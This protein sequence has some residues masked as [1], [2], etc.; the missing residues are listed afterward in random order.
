[1]RKLFTFIVFIII[2][3]LILSSAEFD[4]DKYE[5][6]LDSTKNL[7]YE[8]LK[9]LYPSDPFYSNN[10][11]NLDSVNYYELSKS[12]LYYSKDEIDLLKNQSFVVSERFNYATFFHSIYDIW[13]KDLPI[14]LSYDLFLN[15][16]HTNFNDIFKDI[17]AENA[18]TLSSALDSTLD[19]LYRFKSLNTRKDKIYLNMVDDAELYL[20]IAK[21]LLEQKFEIQID[22]AKK[23]KI[24]EVLNFIEAEKP[25]SVKLFAKV[26]RLYDFSLFKPRGFYTETEYKHI[27]KS[28]TLKDYFKSIMWLGHINIYIS[29]PKNNAVFNLDDEDLDRHTRLVAFLSLLISKSGAK[30]LF[31]DIDQRLRLLV[32]DQDNITYNQSN[33]IIEKL[34]YSYDDL[35]E[36]ENI[37]RIRTEL[38]KLSSAK[39]TYNST[40]LIEGNPNEKIDAGAVF[41]VLG[42]RPLIDAFIT[43]KVVF[44]NIIYDG[45]KIRRMLP[46]SMDVLFALGN[47]ATLFGLK[48]ELNEYHYSSNLASVRYLIDGFEESFWKK[49]VYTNWLGVIRS[50]NPPLTQEERDTK[51]QFEQSA[52]WQQKTATAQLAS[53]AELRHDFILQG[54]QPTTSA[55]TC[56]FPDA[57]LEPNPEFFQY[58]LNI[59]NI[60]KD[61]EKLF[62]TNWEGINIILTYYSRLKD[63]SQDIEYKLPLS[64]EDKKFLKQVLFDCSYSSCDHN[65]TDFTGWL[66][67]LYYGRRFSNTAQ[68]NA[69]KGPRLAV[70]DIH[71]SPTDEDGNFVGWVKH[72]GTG[73]VNL[74]SVITDN[75]DEEKKIYTG[76]VYSFYEFTTENFHRLDDDEW[77]NEFNQELGG[78]FEKL[79]KSSI[80]KAYTTN[81]KGIVYSK[82]PIFET[83]ESVSAVNTVINNENRGVEV[84]PQ[85]ANNYVRFAF[86]NELSNYTG[87]ISLHSI[88]GDLIQLKNLHF[89]TSGNHIITLSLDR[90]ITSGTYIYRISLGGKEYNGKIIV[91]K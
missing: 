20:I 81:N 74:C 17:E 85:P 40:I 37:E 16:L 91:K 32:G 35:Y 78:T 82:I 14:Y 1:M 66:P 8:G 7:D 47:N 80:S 10:Y 53:W 70:A 88:D 52:L 3:N 39:Q 51:R 30:L 2:S 75:D 9:V 84:Y 73:P 23:A 57:F 79:Q 86:P 46:Q 43:S 59:Y 63:I 21:K 5:K 42:Q 77:V 45:K 15:N 64:E 68:L 24:M 22:S 19:E 18:I 13:K 28:I 56:E 36:A 76:P 69:I 27:P 26:D 72:V 38:L 44:D 29:N 71:T 58:I 31:D 67:K 12:K 54:K 60:I 33:T 41:L 11:T 87:F 61:N 83:K 6:F 25:A 50:M 34:Q 49:N 48:D 4:I 65:E 55:L 62:N 90:R 89:E